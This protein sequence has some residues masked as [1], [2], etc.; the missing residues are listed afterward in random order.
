MNVKNILTVGFAAVIGLFAWID[1]LVPAYEFLH[2]PPAKTIT[3]LISESVHWK[4]SVYPRAGEGFA[5]ALLLFFII[6]ASILGVMKFGKNT[7]HRLYGLSIIDLRITLLFDDERMI[8]SKM[9]RVQRYHA[10]TRNI[11]AYVYTHMTDSID[12]EVDPNCFFLDSRVDGIKITDEL[13][14]TISKKKIDIIELFSQ[15]LRSSLIMKFIPTSIKRVLIDNSLLTDAF[16]VRTG[17][18][19]H[20]NE[21]NGKFPR[22]SVKSAQRPVYNI[23]LEVQFHVNT[24]PDPHTVRAFEISENAAKSLPVVIDDKKKPGIVIYST[25]MRR[26]Y[27]ASIE[28]RWENTNL[29]NLYPTA[30]T[31]LT[32]GS[33]PTVI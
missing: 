4:N 15:P 12:G 2:G 22:F 21:F 9:K 31:Q 20:Y 13:L 16:V 26:L 18:I 14:T 24:A 33:S 32:T 8:Y 19:C 5:F 10:N 28:L 11:T 6:L 7:S 29:H 1:L 17:E 27:K 3:A 23:D 25:K 30:T